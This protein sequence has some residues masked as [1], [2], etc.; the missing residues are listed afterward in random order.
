MRLNKRV[1]FF[2]RRPKDDGRGNLRQAFAA[3]PNFVMDASV[4]P[5]FGGE[6]VMA[7]RLA[8]RQIYTITVRG[9]R[10]V[11]DVTTEWQL[12]NMRS[13]ELL[14]IRSITNPDGQ[15]QWFEI[16]AETGGAT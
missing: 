15:G 3:T 1:G 10:D 9:C 4:E 7:A 12:K 13:Q 8:G 6:T 11:R 14:N 2:A 5:R 16:L